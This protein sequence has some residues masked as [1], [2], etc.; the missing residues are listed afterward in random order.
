MRKA[1]LEII[2]SDIFHYKP[3]LEWLKETFSLNKQSL[4]WERW[5]DKIDS[6]LTYQTNRSDWHNGIDWETIEDQ[7]A[8][9]E[10]QKQKKEVA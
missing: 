3:S 5:K 8:Y 1:K 2:W 6:P 10:K 7:I 9:E 4:G